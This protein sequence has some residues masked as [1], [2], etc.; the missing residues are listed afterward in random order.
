[1]NRLSQGSRERETL[2]HTEKTLDAPA[3]HNEEAIVCS[4]LMVMVQDRRGNEEKRL[5]TEKFDVAAP[6]L[7]IC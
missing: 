5:L 7:S 3:L 2:A 6:V 1:M 4:L